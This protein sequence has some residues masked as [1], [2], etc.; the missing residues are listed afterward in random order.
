MPRGSKSDVEASDGSEEESEEGEDVEDSEGED[1]E[2]DDEDDDDDEDEDNEEDEDYEDEESDGEKEQEEETRVAKTQKDGDGREVPEMLQVTAVER[3]EKS[4]DDQPD[5][6]TELIIRSEPSKTLIEQSDH[7]KNPFCLVEANFSENSDL[8]EREKLEDMKRRKIMFS[9]I[10]DDAMDKAVPHTLDTEVGSLLSGVRVESFSNERENDYISRTPL[11]ISGT[12]PKIKKNYEGDGDEDNWDEGEDSEPFGFGKHS[13]VGVLEF[14]ENTLLA[15]PNITT[16]Q[17][18]TDGTV[19]KQPYERDDKKQ[20]TNNMKADNTVSETFSATNQ[21]KADDDNNKENVN[22]TT[23]P[24]KLIMNLLRHTQEP[25]SSED[26]WGSGSANKKEDSEEGDT[27]DTF[28]DD[29]KL[30]VSMIVGSNDLEDTESHIRLPAECVAED[31]ELGC[32]EE[33]PQTVIDDIDVSSHSDKNVEDEENG[34]LKVQEHVYHTV[35]KQVHG[36]IT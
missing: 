28:Y 4:C 11:Q 15:E 25:E 16:N 9:E 7:T 18:E 23:V 5:V 1:E 12:T 26:T 14:A 31:K 32:H 19:S 3:S 30:P 29:E 35:P 21:V 2:E 6:N 8:I 22:D 24:S 27:S 17:G 13:N 20:I 36:R 10:T 34:N 33:I